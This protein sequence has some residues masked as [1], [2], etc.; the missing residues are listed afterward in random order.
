[1][2][3]YEVFISAE[4]QGQADMVLNSLLEKKLVTGGQ[5]IA[6]PA[7]FLWKGE[8]TNREYFTITSFTTEY[9]KDAVIQDVKRTSDES[10][11]MIRFVEFIGNE[12]LLRW[13][14][15]TLIQTL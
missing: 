6:T 10:V 4:D 5:F 13:I 11:P 2:K 8:I 14:N 1:M 15:D 7:R 12:E 9:H 3:Y